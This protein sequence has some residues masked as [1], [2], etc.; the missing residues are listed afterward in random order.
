MEGTSIYLI[1]VD[2]ED[3]RKQL[4][5]QMLELGVEDELIYEYFFIAQMNI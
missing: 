2:A 1:A 4:R 5:M 3:H